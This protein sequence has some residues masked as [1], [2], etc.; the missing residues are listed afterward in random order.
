MPMSTELIAGVSG[1]LIGGGLSIVGSWF[2]IKKQFSEQRKL[3]LEQEEM[4]QRTAV[5]SVRDEILHN[6]K[7]LSSVKKNLLENLEQDYIQYNKEQ[8]RIVLKDSSWGKHS[9]DVRMVNTLSDLN[10][11]QN[12]YIRISLANSFDFIDKS[13]ITTLIE[14]CE[15]CDKILMKH[16]ELISKK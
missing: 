7:V 15:K 1:A 16:M 5:I 2:S 9:D 12:L 6:Y 4:K 11:I 10:S 13:T 14:D 8:F 3:F